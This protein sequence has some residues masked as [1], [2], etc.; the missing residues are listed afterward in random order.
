VPLSAPARLAQS[1]DALYLR[2]VS[3][4]SG[5]VGEF[6]R[7]AASENTEKSAEERKWAVDVRLFLAITARRLSSKTKSSKTP[8]SQDRKFFN[9]AGIAQ[10]N[11]GRR[12]ANVDVL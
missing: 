9:E 10:S 11:T 5:Q 7:Q 4:A 6:C 3:P 2:R 12:T 8:L 1:E